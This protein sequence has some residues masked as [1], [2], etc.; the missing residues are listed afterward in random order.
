MKKQ[1]IIKGEDWENS[2]YNTREWEKSVEIIRW[3]HDFVKKQYVIDYK[4]Q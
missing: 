1:I 4:V 2:I 3:E